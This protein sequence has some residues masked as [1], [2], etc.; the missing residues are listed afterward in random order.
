MAEPIRQANPGTLRPT[1]NAMSATYRDL[2][3]TVI[4]IQGTNDTPS[5]PSPP[6]I[7][8]TNFIQKQI[9]TLTHT[10]YLG[11]ARTHRYTQTQAIAHVYENLAHTQTQTVD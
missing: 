3:T 5:P 10:N 2:P 11:H 7:R 4:D 8:L 6:H 1:A 9:F